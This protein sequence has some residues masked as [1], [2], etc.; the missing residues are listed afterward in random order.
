MSQETADRLFA[1]AELRGRSMAGEV[2]VAVE[3]HLARYVREL[4]NNGGPAADDRPSLQDRPSGGAEH[5]L[6]I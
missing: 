3:A 1:L 2:R 5:G 6:P 4:R